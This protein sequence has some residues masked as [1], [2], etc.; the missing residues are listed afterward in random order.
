[1]ALAVPDLAEHDSQLGV[2]QGLDPV[3]QHRRP[4]QP[5]RPRHRRIG[6]R[7]HPQR[8]PAGTCGIVDGQDAHIGMQEPG[9][10]DDLRDRS[11]R[12]LGRP[13]R[14]PIRVGPPQVLPVAGDADRPASGICDRLDS[15]PAWHGNLHQG[16][17]VDLIRPLIRD[18][19]PEPVSPPT[20]IG[21]RER[22]PGGPRHRPGVRPLAQL[23]REPQRS[24]PG[25]VQQVHLIVAEARRCRRL[26]RHR[27]P[28]GRHGRWPELVVILLVCRLAGGEPL[29]RRVRRINGQTG[30]LGRFGSPQADP[31]ATQQDA[32]LGIASALT[33]SAAAAAA[34]RCARSLARRGEPAM[35]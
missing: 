34:A 14:D 22:G 27:L 23:R 28:P 9:R 24:Q 20:K 12:R 17:L 21:R 32:Q 33:L 7:Y 10:V 4:G 5:A 31:L 13:D 29:I 8:G 1:M 3:G 25:A 26:P 11:R 18:A 16:G 2:D 19:L 35:A 30:E 6:C 15:V